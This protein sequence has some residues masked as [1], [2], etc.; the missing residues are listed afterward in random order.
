M[1]A[2]NCS[3]H[4]RSLKRLFREEINLPTEIKEAQKIATVC[5]LWDPIVRGIVC[6]I[7][8][9]ITSITDL[10]WITHNKDVLHNLSNNPLG[11]L[12]VAHMR[13]GCGCLQRSVRLPG[14]FYFSWMFPLPLLGS[15]P[16]GNTPGLG[17]GQSIIPRGRGLSKLRGRGQGQGQFIVIVPEDEDKDILTCPH[18]D[19][20]S[21]WGQQ[22]ILLNAYI[23]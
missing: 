16:I 4:D 15:S 12:I 6:Q 10:Y 17:R 20:L 13:C 22:V 7:G 19:K 9:S 1:N 2:L 23:S 3:C 11:I 14:C 21:S 8:L 5:N 18:E